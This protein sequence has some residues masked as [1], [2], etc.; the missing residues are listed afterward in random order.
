MATRL[1]VSSPE[2]RSC[3]D[4]VEELRAAGLPC[5]VTPNWTVVRT[6]SPNDREEPFRT[7]QGCR[8]LLTEGWEPKAW[9]VLRDRF[10]LQCAHLSI[11][12]RFEG[13]VRDWERASVCPGRSE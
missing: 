8:V 5:D 12:G 7:E 11:P 9:R 1:S 3:S 4:V 2:I 10:R 13:C 6:Q